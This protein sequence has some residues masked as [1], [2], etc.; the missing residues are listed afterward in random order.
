MSQ[1][2]D[3][4]E[5]AT[6][7]E[8]H[9][10][11]IIGAGP[12]GLLLGQLLTRSGIDIPIRRINTVEFRHGLLDRM[13]RTGTLVIESASG[14][15]LLFDDVPEVAGQV[16]TAAAAHLL[17]TQAEQVG[18]LEEHLTGHAGPALGEQAHDGQRR[19]GRVLDD[20]EKDVALAQSL[21]AQRFDEFDQMTGDSVRRQRLGRAG[22][23]GRHQLSLSSPAAFT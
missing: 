5:S 18:A 7:V 6:Q 22:A 1:V 4:A 19:R 12:S 21:G 15:P 8:E 20:V 13:L 9:D 16:T 11:V 23:S 2:L 17:G 14:E 10:I 3:T